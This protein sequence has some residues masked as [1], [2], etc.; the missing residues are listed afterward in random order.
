MLGYETLQH[1]AVVKLH[2][3]YT[4]KVKLHEK[5]WIPKKSSKKYVQIHDIE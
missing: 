4:K 2:K 1:N 5:M 3:N